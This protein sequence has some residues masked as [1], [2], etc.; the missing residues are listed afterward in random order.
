MKRGKDEDKT[1]GPMFP[2]LH[3]NDTEKGGPRAPP[4]NKMALYEQL[5][6]P[7]QRLNGG[8]PS[9]SNR[10]TMNERGTFS[11][12][13][14]ASSNHP[15]RKPE[16]RRSEFN[17][18]RVQQEH[19]RRQEEDD[20]T[21][22]IFDQQSGTSQN[23]SVVHQNRENE[24]VT[25]SGAAFSGR[26]V[27][28]H[29]AK[30][31][32][33]KSQKNSQDFATSVSNQWA[34]QNVKSPLKETNESSSFSHR[35]ALN[36]R[37]LRDHGADS[38]ADTTLWGDSVLNEASKATGYENNSVPLSETQKEGLQS[39]NDPTN[40]D[41]VSENSMVDSICGV[42]IS[43]DDVV[44]LIGQKHFWKA[45]RA[46][47]NQQRVFSVQVFELHRLIKVQ[48]LIAGSPE[49]LVDENAYLTEPPKVAPIKKIPIKYVLKPTIDTP[50]NINDLEKNDDMEFSAENAVGKASLSSVQNG[51]Q[52]TYCRP[53]GG[54]PL[55]PS[56]QNMGSWNFNPPPGPQWLIPVMSPS[57][58]LVYKPYPASGFMNS[59]YGGCGPP[60]SMPVTGH[61][62]PNYGALPSQHHHYEGHT[63]V[64]P[65]TPLPASHSYFPPYSMQMSNPLVSGS[66]R[67]EPTN[68]FNLQRQGSTN[69]QTE[70]NGHAVPDVVKFNSASKDAEVQ[71]STVSSQSDTPNDQNALALFPTSPPVSTPAPEPARVETVGPPRVIRVVPHNARSATASVARIF[72]SIQEERKQHDS[73]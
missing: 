43:P 25:P 71:A 44:G 14:Q 51:S 15:N 33:S 40:G 31:N 59:V 46:I 1:M 6:I 4:R 24:G 16:T 21:V 47:V 57:E 11:S 23:R 28:N 37:N 29:E 54:H 20:F 55:P 53:F 38:Q 69:V 41:A 52:T 8:A 68:P 70:K 64:N 5:S 72:Q 61:H 58:G 17:N 67:F 19:K 27:N 12:H 42:D 22:P 66:S 35:N 32:N 50:K 18:H 9:S 39:P 3:V 26:L 73:G 36:N 7:S 65:F 30:Q 56:D 34:Q 60:G 13:P 49:L 2:R 45:R 63:G 48:K 10:A 62:F